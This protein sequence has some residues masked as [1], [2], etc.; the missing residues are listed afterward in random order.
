MKSKLCLLYSLQFY[1]SMF[2]FLVRS[3]YQERI[4][5]KYCAT[6]VI[7]RFHR[8]KQPSDFYGIK[9]LL[10]CLL[11]QH[12]WGKVSKTAGEQM[13]D[14]FLCDINLQDTGSF[15][16]TSSDTVFSNSLFPLCLPRLLRCQAMFFFFF[17]QNEGVEACLW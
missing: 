17:C 7:F 12:Q 1:S 8:L 4:L 11:L 3:N 2:N 10:Y 6:T 13:K 5:E 9:A 16:I 14:F 15:R